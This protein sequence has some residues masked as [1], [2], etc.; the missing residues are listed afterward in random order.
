LMEYG[1]EPEEGASLSALTQQCVLRFG[2]ELLQ[3][4]FQQA[5]APSLKK[6]LSPFIDA[7]GRLIPPGVHF[8]LLWEPYLERA[9][10]E[11]QPQRTVYAIQPSL[12]SS[13]GKPRVI[14]RP[15]GGS[16][17]KMEPV[18]PRRF[19]LDNEIVVVRLYGG[20]S[21][22]PRPVY[23]QPLLTEDDHLQGLLGA[24]GLRPPPWMEELMARPRIQP[25]LFVGLSILE[26]RY[27]LLLA[28]LYDRRPAPNDSLALLTP[29]FN[30]GEPDIWD[31]GGGL[32]GKGRIAPIIE[33]PEQLA[34][35]LEAFVPEM[36][37]ER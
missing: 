20:Y 3:S 14:K 2:E 24:E 29:A 33:D 17:W 8:T 32:P 27:R 28:W 30:A 5:L 6:P 22:E 10:A 36:G 19:D 21:P 26:W 11:K 16:A 25:G 23:S 15:V 9:I 37:H 31:G 18:L 7:L 34:S 13:G 4:V 1:V 35:L 12:M